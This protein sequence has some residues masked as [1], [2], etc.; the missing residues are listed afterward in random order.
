MSNT[1]RIHLGKV[2]LS[3]LCRLLR[4]MLTAHTL[5]FVKEIPGHAVNS[6]HNYTSQNTG[7]QTP[8]D[9]CEGITELSQLTR[10]KKTTAFFL[11]ECWISLL[12]TRHETTG[13]TQDG[14]FTGT[15]AVSLGQG[16][17]LDLQ[18]RMIAFQMDSWFSL[19]FTFLPCKIE[20]YLPC[21][22]TK[23]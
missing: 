4:R 21:D 16:L 12:E 9:C 10:W 13:L 7:R 8:W 18:A 20:I 17:R 15:P 11:K 19:N 6:I 3:S 1:N 2:R 22:T 14:I 23:D 5:T